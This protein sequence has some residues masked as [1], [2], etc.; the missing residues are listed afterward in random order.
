M[1][2]EHSMK[3]DILII[4][5]DFARLGSREVPKFKENVIQLINDS[6]KHDV[7]FDLN[8]LNYIDSQGVSSFLSLLRLLN[9]KGGDLKL[10]AVTPPIRISLELVSLHK[11]FEIF[12]TTDDAIQSFNP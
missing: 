1:Q 11:V 8:Q 3:D 6:K 4:K 12:K 10:A 2:L 9:S 5:P 7:V